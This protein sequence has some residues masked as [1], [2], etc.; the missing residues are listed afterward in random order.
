MTSELEMSAAAPAP[1][2]RTSSLLG[3][4]SSARTFWQKVVERDPSNEAGWL[5]LAS[6]ANN[7]E[8]AIGYLRRVLEI[9]PQNEQAL[10]SLHKTLVNEG[11]RLAKADNRSRARWLLMEASALNPNSELV[12]LSLAAVVEKPADAVRC[13]QKV[14]KINPNNEQ[15]IT[16][17]NQ[18]YAKV[19]SP[20]PAWQCPICLS[21]FQ[22][23]MTNCA[24]CRAILTLTD[25]DAL[26]DNRAADRVMLQDALRRYSEAAQRADDPGAY[27]HLALAF[28]N[29]GQ[30]AEG[31]HALRRASQMQPEDQGLK[32]L[33]VALQQRQTQTYAADAKTILVIDD[34]PTVCKLVSLSLEQ[35]GHRVLVASEMMEAL[36]KLNESKLDLIL[37]DIMLPGA[38]GYQVCKIIKSY[39][40]TKTVPV[41]MLS[42]RDGFFD[43]MRARLVGAQGYITKPFVP[44]DLLKAV[45]KHCK[46]GK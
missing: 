46:K 38:D 18:I 12:W 1:E 14:L 32:N 7:D 25:L 20:E 26:L 23:E 22:M 42:G 37:L 16:C 19:G 4:A 41:V 33:I 6:F 45:E 3:S 36:A 27:Y 5:G 30:I 35:H 29:N 34:S 13:L 44:N 10:T 39:A 28:L 43:K 17:L 24:H 31:T 40:T 2:A 21:S 9:N 11:I 15:A 8:E